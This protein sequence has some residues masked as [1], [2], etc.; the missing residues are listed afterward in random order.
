MDHS[1]FFYLAG[2]PV[3]GLVAQWLAWRLRVPSILL[4]LL[5]G[6][7]LGFFVKI[8]DLLLNI[9]DSE[10]PFLAAQIL[11][12]IVSLSVAVILFE[13]GL[14]LKFSELH[15]S[16]KTVLRLVTLG[17]LIS[18]ILTSLAASYLLGFDYRLAILL[19]A[20]L[21]VTGPTVVAP[22]IRHI[23]P[24]R[25]VASIVKWEGIVVDPIGAVL[26]VLVFELLFHSSHSD[27]PVMTALSLITLT[28]VI[29]G[30]FGVAIGWMLT[31][32]VAK[33]WI[34]DHLHGVLF[35]ASA[36]GSF[37]L[38]N[39]IVEESGLV[40]VT[41]L[42]IF[43]ANQKS[44][45]LD[46]IVQFKENLGVILISCLFIILGSRLDLSS[47]LD[48]GIWRLLFL[49]A[50]ILVIRPASVLLSSWGTE[51]S[52]REQLLVGAL[53]PRGIVAAAVASVFALKI[54]ADSHN[55]EDMVGLAEQA[56]ALV[57]VTFLVIIGT[58]MFYGLTS[59][60]L[61]RALH[62][63]DSNPQGMLIAGAESWIQKLAHVLDKAGVPVVLVD[64]NYRNVSEAR[65]NGLRAYCSSILSETIEESA[66][67]SGIGRLLAMTGNDEVNVLATSEYAHLFG[68]ANVYQL[69][70]NNESTGGRGSVKE[71]KRA[72]ELFG[73]GLNQRR[74]SELV[75]QGHE[76]KAT[77]LTDEYTLDDFRQTH[78]EEAKIL[79]LIDSP[80]RVQ[81]SLVGETMRSDGKQTVIA[82]IPPKPASA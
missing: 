57:P 31:K 33:F 66:D 22:M 4:L 16:G 6:V 41:V 70:P 51:A 49:A 8:D 67:L 9:A 72:R 45:S 38:S 60:P 59:A 74:L 24:T 13:G 2:V 18:W 76:M 29:G 35:L 7:G 71:L 48:D 11:F 79:F 43:L 69:P 19:G 62:L 1:L 28:A 80:Q 68:K 78:G 50:L 63:A 10:E 34:P 3:L 61:A 47:L 32:V 30:V 37:A 46:H 15:E 75:R 36:L 20:I 55:S 23:R 14:T 27:Q 44:V 26:A 58:V 53:A 65:M 40:T 82:L 77:P 42:G 64:T 17:A 21:V 52:F 25:K 54:I 81:I 39:L 56:E 5:G 12:P 73:G